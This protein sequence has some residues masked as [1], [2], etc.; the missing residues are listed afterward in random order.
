MGTPLI[1]CF[2]S[3]NKEWSFETL[4]TPFSNPSKGRDPG[5]HPQSLSICD[6]TMWL[7]DM[8]CTLLDLWVMNICLGVSCNRITTGN[9]PATI[10]ALSGERSMEAHPNLCGPS[11]SP[12]AFP[13]DSFTIKRLRLMIVSSMISEFSLHIEVNLSVWKHLTFSAPL[14][15]A[16]PSGLWC[17]ISKFC[18]VLV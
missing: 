18:L 16:Y 9:S 7:M 13:A 10:L 12:R 17:G 8:L 6:L 1:L 4:G 2:K 11:G 14:A 15:G 5:L 3:A